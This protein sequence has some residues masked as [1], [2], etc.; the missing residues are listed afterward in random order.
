MT[1][2]LGYTLALLIG[3]SLGLLG[4]GGSILT[5][6]VL[7]YVL[8]YGVK[9][10]IPMSLVVVGLTAGFGAIAHGRRGSVDGRAALAFGPPAIVGSLLGADLGLRVAPSVQLS[11]FAIVMLAAAVSMLRSSKLVSDATR[12]GTRPLPLVTLAGAGV[13]LLTGFVGVGG[14]FLYVP[15]LSLLGGLPIKRAIGTSLVL[16]L[17]SCAAGV[18]RY[19][20]A[21]SLDW[22]AIALFSAIAFAG[23]AAGSRLV[24]YVSQQALKR[25]FAV[26]LLVVGTFVLAYRR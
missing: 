14:G 23:V 17:L 11:V 7:H 2:I 22:K 15:A 13:G 8:G 24:P 5:V 6:P 26:F 25:G 21:V 3:L 12:H 9:E 19:H 1:P 18:V 4:G 20:G 16:I 10:A